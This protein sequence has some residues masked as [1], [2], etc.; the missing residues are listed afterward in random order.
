MVQK[1][2]AIAQT[3]QKEYIEALSL[4]GGTISAL[5]PP[6]GSAKPN[7]RIEPTFLSLATDFQ[8]L[9]VKNYQQQKFKIWF[10]FGKC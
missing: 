4:A 6:F 3:P 8:S 2:K 7:R 10:N 5:G 9:K 1:S